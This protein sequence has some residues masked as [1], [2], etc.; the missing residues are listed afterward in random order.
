MKIWHMDDTTT[1]TNFIVWDVYDQLTIMGKVENPSTLEVG[2]QVKSKMHSGKVFCF[3]IEKIDF[4][5]IYFFEAQL[6]ELGYE[7][8]INTDLVNTAYELCRKISE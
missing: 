4:Y 5:N 6:M 1:P 3:M 2:D 8:E 7:N